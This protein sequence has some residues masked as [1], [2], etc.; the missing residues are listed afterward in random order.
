MMYSNTVHNHSVQS[1]ASYSN[2]V[3]SSYLY[4][5]FKGLREELIAIFNSNAKL[6]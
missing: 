4:S 2:N 6:P 3:M 5:L 1:Q